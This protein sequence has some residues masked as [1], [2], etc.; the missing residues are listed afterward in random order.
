MT[1]TLKTLL[2]VLILG[3]PLFYVFYKDTGSPKANQLKT[4][5]SVLVADVTAEIRYR[6]VVD[7]L[8]TII[9][10][11]DSIIQSHENRLKAISKRTNFLRSRYDSI[12]IVRPKY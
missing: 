3:L 12:I 4:I 11:Q 7:S 6:K 8:K 1:N 10:Q 5:D 2:A 9:L